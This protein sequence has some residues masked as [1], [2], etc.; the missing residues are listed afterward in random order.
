MSVFAGEELDAGD[1]DGAGGSLARAGEEAEHQMELRARSQEVAQ[2]FSC[3][4][5]HDITA[6]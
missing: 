6:L 4:Q 5:V 2:M 3:Q 1:F